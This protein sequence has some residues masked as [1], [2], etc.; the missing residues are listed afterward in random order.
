M[1]PLPTTDPTSSDPPPPAEPPVAA[2]TAPRLPQPDLKADPT[3]LIDKDILAGGTPPYLSPQA[4]LTALA[5]DDPLTWQA[6]LRLVW[7]LVTQEANTAALTS[8]VP[9]LL[10]IGQGL[11]TSMT[12]ADKDWPEEKA[13]MTEG[14]TLRVPLKTL[15][16]ALADTLTAIS[17]SGA[18]GT[19]DAIGTADMVT[20]LVNLLS[21]GP[22]ESTD[23]QGSGSRA[24]RS[25]QQDCNYD[26]AF[27]LY[28][29]ETWKGDLSGLVDDA[30]PAKIV[31]R[32]RLARLLTSMTAA[33]GNGA[34]L[35]MAKAMEPLTKLLLADTDIDHN[36]RC[37]ESF[38]PKDQAFL[39]DQLRVELMDLAGKST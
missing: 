34:K 32:A 5:S 20:C 36:R 19:A 21:H 6:A 11:Y 26:S 15:V 37:W 10:K 4:L 30:V 31:P 3:T 9:T 13:P 24:E 12:A 25:S 23:F 28:G 16:I 8:A 27:A 14:Q 22:L 7:R 1:L 35:V 38:V 2:A 39:H 18:A 17:K 29:P 33:G